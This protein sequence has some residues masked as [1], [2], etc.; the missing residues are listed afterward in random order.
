MSVHKIMDASQPPTS[1]PADVA[2]VAGYIGG[3]TPHVWTVPEWQ[4]FAR[5]AQFP[6]WV[7]DTTTHPMGQALDAVAAMRRLGWTQFQPDPGRRALIVDMET[8][9]NAPWY[10]A[11]ADIINNSGYMAVIYGSLS[12]VL[13]NAAADVLAADWDNSPVIPAGQTIHGVQFLANVPC[14]GTRVDYDVVDEWL[15]ARAGIGPR[16]G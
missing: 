6:I 14:Q 1:A 9:V 4:R 16:H 12:T 3:R 11:F 13:D 15:F 2:G 10:A 8:T 7:P 5:L